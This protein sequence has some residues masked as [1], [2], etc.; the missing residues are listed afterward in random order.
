MLFGSFGD[1]GVCFRLTWLF[2][3]NRL[4]DLDLSLWLGYSDE[5]YS[6]NVHDTVVFRTWISHFIVYM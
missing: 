2:N 3:R 4:V 1:V 6:N 5:C